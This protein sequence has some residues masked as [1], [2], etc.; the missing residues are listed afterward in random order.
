ME[1][2]PRSTETVGY[3]QISPTNYIHSDQ[4]VC[5]VYISIYDTNSRKRNIIGQIHIHKIDT[6]CAHAVGCIVIHFIYLLYSKC[7]YNLLS[8]CRATRSGVPDS[9]EFYYLRELIVRSRVTWL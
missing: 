1:C 8:D 6:C 5:A 7:I 4:Y 2:H 9:L 3:G